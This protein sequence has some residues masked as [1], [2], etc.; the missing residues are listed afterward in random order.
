[1]IGDLSPVV[2]LM[3]SCAMVVATFDAIGGSVAAAV[4]QRL[5]RARRLAINCAP[6]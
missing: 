4:R 2:A 6:I 1:M 3:P 5:P